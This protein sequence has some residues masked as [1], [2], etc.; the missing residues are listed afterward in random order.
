MLIAR[1]TSQMSSLAASS[2]S[3]RQSCLFV[4]LFLSLDLGQI[5]FMNCERVCVCVHI[6]NLVELSTFARLD[7]WQ[8]YVFLASKKLELDAYF[9]CSSQ[10]WEYEI[11]FSLRVYC[12]PSQDETMEIS[13]DKSIWKSWSLLTAWNAREKKT[14]THISTAHRNTIAPP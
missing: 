10:P 13:K 6:S 7:K 4:S 12:S 5:L 11:L 1:E 8:R 14:N 3:L 9:S 2:A